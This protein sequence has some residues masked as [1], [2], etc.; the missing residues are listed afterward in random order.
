MKPLM[1]IN[2]RRVIDLTERKLALILG[3]LW[4][5]KISFLSLN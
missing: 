2:M 1:L 3:Q 5:A 4:V